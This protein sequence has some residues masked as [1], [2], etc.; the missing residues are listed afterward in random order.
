MPIRKMDC[1]HSP[2]HTEIGPYKFAYQ[3]SEVNCKNDI[4]AEIK[5][6]AFSLQ[7]DVPM[8][9]QSISNHT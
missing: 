2:S 8:K 4:Q 9:L 1:M 7:T 5:K 3:G 6:T